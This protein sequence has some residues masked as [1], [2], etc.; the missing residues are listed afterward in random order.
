M[1]SSLAFFL[2]LEGGTL[3]G[4]LSRVNCHGY[5]IVPGHRYLPVP[6]VIYQHLGQTTNM[7]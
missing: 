4:K 6:V 1:P 7:H 5:I 2:Y 3:P